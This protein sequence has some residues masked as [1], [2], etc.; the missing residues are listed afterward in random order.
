LK[1]FK[2]LKQ[3]QET[4]AKTGKE[5][6]LKQNDTPS[7][8]TLLYLTYNPYLTYRV[9]QLEDPPK[10][11]IVQPDITSELNE[12]LLNLAKH[13]T[14]PTQARLLI[15]S[16][17]TKCTEDGAG[18]VKKIIN[19]DL[20]IGISAS[21]IN[22]AFPGLVPQ[23]DVQLAHPI[24]DKK[25]GT[26]RWDKV[27]YPVVVEEKFDGMRIVAVCDGDAV[28]YFSREGHSIDL[29]FLD[30]QILA[31]RPGTKFV[32]DGEG[33]GIKYN[34][35]CAVAKKAYDAGKPW[36][37]PQGLSMIK[38]KDKY[39]LAD[40]KEYVGYKVWDVID[41]DFFLS[42][43]EKGIRR[44]LKERKLELLSLFERADRH[45]PNLHLVEN[46][47]AHS[48]EEVINLFRKFREAGSEGVIIKDVS[49]PYEF[50]RSDAA[51]KFKEFYTADLRI[52]DCLEGSKGSKY[53]GMLG[54]LLVSDGTVTGKVMGGFDDDQ[55]LEFW[56]AHR[57]G[58]M[59]GRICE[60]D[61]MEIT[62]DNSLRHAAFIRM[63]DDKEECSWN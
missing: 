1:E 39:S 23:F 9:Q 62:A 4:S 10:F 46:V 24:V 31:L 33:I 59:I 7:L 38:S 40:M 15:R 16:L 44:P 49:K 20:K 17:L 35:K 29:H 19:R 37:F 30:S 32:L 48:R 50:K 21:T 41:Y 36:C 34:P 5:Q 26:D 54:T 51:L 45:L 55:R 63:R 14:T 22:K 12:L 56:L 28:Q 11:N 47:V 2:V 57:R 25:N 13:T 42:Q 61:Y 60:I 27:S 52:I 6:L 3:I 43:G 18:W 53:E 8:R 58:G